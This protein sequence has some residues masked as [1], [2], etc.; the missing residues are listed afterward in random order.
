MHDYENWSIDWN[1]SEFLPQRPL[2]NCE[3]L[4]L[5]CMCLRLICTMQSKKLWNLPVRYW[6]FSPVCSAAF[7]WY[8]FPCRGIDFISRYFRTLGNSHQLQLMLRDYTAVWALSQTPP[9]LPLTS[10]ELPLKDD[11]QYL[12]YFEQIQWRDQNHWCVCPYLSTG[13]F[14]ICLW[15]SASSSFVAIEDT[16]HYT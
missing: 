6:L 13:D 16:D 15:R 5:K 7:A 11:I 8:C 9:A 3:W 14:I 4:H 10:Y 2:T 12:S 1:Q